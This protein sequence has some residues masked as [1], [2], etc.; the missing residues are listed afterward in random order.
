MNKVVL[1]ALCSALT[2]CAT[3]S[4]ADIPR[5]ADTPPDPRIC[6]AEPDA[7]RLPD[8]AGLVAPDTEAEE[9]QMRAFLVWVA[10]LQAHS[11]MGWAL[12]ALARQSCWE[13]E[14]ETQS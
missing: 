9:A 7:P 13:A 12:V 2:S 5:P 4:I 6:A 8:T 1:C 11:R 3:P 14:E 10:K